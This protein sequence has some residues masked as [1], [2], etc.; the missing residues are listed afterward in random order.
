MSL[1]E[2]GTRRPRSDARDQVTARILYTADMYLPGMLQARPLLSTEH[3]AKI[4]NIDTRAAEA[5]PGVRAVITGRDVPNNLSGQII[6]DVPILPLD[7][8]RYRGE[9]VALVAAETD[10]IAAEAVSRI[11]VDYEPLPAVFDAREA[12]QPGAPLVH[13]EGQGTL[14]KGNVVLQHGH[15]SSRLVH[16]DVEKGFAESDVI[17]EESFA[18]SSQKCAPIEPHVALARP[19]GPDKI[20]IWA[21]TQCPHGHAPLIAAA[22]GLPLNRVRL[23]A[24]AL[25]GGFGQKNSMTIEGMTAVVAMKAK[26]PVKLA[27]TTT[28]DFLYGH[29]RNPMYS[30]LKLGAKSD[31]TLV[32]IERKHITNAGAYASIA[33]LITGKTAMIGTGPYRVPNQLAEA[34]VVYTNKTT[35]G[36]MRG[37]GMA[38]PTFAMESMMDVLAARLRMDPLE[39][40]MKN[41]LMDGDCNGTGQFIL[42]PGIK[43]CL[44]AVRTMANWEVKTS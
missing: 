1:R 17:V 40:R 35:G 23:I 13:E 14:C 29:T 19:E 41:I 39:L 37:F 33:I 26:R 8:V 42:N 10:E 12:M 21:A 28:E 18:T 2:V 16:G 4:L 31:G 5:L 24:P 38:Q 27:L 32:A 44:D 15:E 11:R 6:Q 25:G 36:A 30:H 20:T 3:H 34:W 43:Q 7:K 22:L 9:I